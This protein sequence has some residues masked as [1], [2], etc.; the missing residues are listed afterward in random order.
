[1]KAKE[2]IIKE[3]E[4]FRLWLAQCDASLDGPRC[5]Y[6]WVHDSCFVDGTTWDNRRVTVHVGWDIKGAYAWSGRK[7][8]LAESHNRPLGTLVLEP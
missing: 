2:R 4:A 1:M 5:T 8:R 6:E 3:R 7:Y